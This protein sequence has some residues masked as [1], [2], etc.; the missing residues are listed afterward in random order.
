MGRQ[1]AE[2]RAR[3]NNTSPDALQIAAALVGVCGASLTNDATPKRVT[4]INVVVLDEVTP[5]RFLRC[6]YFQTAL[7]LT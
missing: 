3:Y 1:A 5:R 4:E 6:A 7:R 2:L